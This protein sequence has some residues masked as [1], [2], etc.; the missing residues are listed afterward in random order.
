VYFVRSGQLGVARRALPADANI[1]RNALEALIAG[2]TAME[3]AAGLS[4]AV[5]SLSR[6][7]DM[8]LEA[9]NIVDVDLTGSFSALGPQGSAELRVAQIVYTLT[10]FP[11]SV[12]FFIEGQ[13]AVAIAGYILPDHPLS[14]D[15]LAA[16]A[17]P[18][19]LESIGPGQVLQPGSDISGST[20]YAGAQVGVQL[21][22]AAGNVVFATS[23]EAKK[24]PERRHLFQTAAE[25]TVSQAG[26]G[27]LTLSELTPAPGTTP[28]VLAIPVE[29]G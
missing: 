9:G 17:P 19:L 13:P 20:E 5:P 21:T 12:R 28:L 4:S 11:V 27:T 25:F 15:D 26:P 1:G 29:L 7:R 10:I 14:R 3:A 8:R 22:D 18:I 2:P 23:A 6:V 16:W 24:G